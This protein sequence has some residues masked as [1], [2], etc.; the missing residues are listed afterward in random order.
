MNAKK[1]KKQKFSYNNYM[2]YNELVGIITK[3]L[4]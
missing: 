3:K 4:L 1:N 2:L